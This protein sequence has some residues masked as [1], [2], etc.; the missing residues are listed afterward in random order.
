MQRAYLQTD[1]AVCQPDLLGSIV[2]AWQ[3][4]L[5]KLAAAANTTAA[6]PLAPV[7]TDRQGDIRLCRWTHVASAVVWCVF[8]QLVGVRPA[9]YCFIAAKNQLERVQYSN[10]SVFSTAT[11]LINH[12]PGSAK[13]IAFV[14]FCQQHRVDKQHCHGMVQTVQHTHAT[15]A[16]L[17]AGASCAM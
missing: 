17:L 11:V 4:V 3:K 7:H 2:S 6:L 13:P 15:S 5:S 16:S 14:V 8:M 12:Q 10:L 9:L 1:A